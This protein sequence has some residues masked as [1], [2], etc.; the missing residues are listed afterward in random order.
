MQE[1]KPAK[2]GRGGKRIPGPGK[3]LGPTPAPGGQRRKRSYF[4]NDEEDRQ[5]KL[6]L[7]TLRTR[8]DG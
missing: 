5:I 3:S 7:A 1:P 4:T 8:K 6:L 2:Q